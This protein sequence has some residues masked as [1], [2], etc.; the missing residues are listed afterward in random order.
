MKY[1]VGDKVRVKEWGD[2]L[3]EFGENEDGNIHTPWYSFTQFMKTYCG[4]HA[5]ITGCYIENDH[6]YY[7]IAIDAIPLTCKEESAYSFVDGF[8]FTDE[9]FEG[10]NNEER[11]DDSPMLLGFDIYNFVKE[12]S[13]KNLSCSDSMTDD[14]CAAYEF[15]KDQILNL[16]KQVL[17]EFFKEDNL[18]APTYIVHVP[19]LN[20][21][22]DFASIDEIHEKFGEDNI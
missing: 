16:L 2:M 17:N 12:F 10:E 9:M 18:T 14:E 20:T 21:A 19:G 15:G 13:G 5:T 1:K 11:N 8:C 22:T 6:G 4:K 3:K 7:N